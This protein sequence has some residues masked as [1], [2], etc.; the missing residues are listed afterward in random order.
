MSE[1]FHL[2]LVSD[3]TGETITSVARACLV[4]FEGVDAVEHVWNLVRTKRQLQRAIAGVENNPGVVLFTLVDAKMRTALE[5]ACRQLQVPCISLLDPA[6]AALS[7]YFGIKSRAKP[8][9]QHALDAEYFARIDA[10]NFV[11]AHDDGQLTK[12]LNE[13]DVVLV[14]ISRTSKT[15]TCIYLANRGVKAA[16][17]PLV[18]GVGLPA[19]LMRATKP[20]IVGLTKDPIPLVQIR[21]NR[22]RSLNQE[23]ETDYIDLEKVKLEVATARRVFAENDWPAIDVTRRSIEE[24]AAAILQL[25]DRRAGRIT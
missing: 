22:L 17:V 13:A 14:G 24:V 18:P 16:N 10:I 23:E 8:G 11:L 5:G 1:R 7:E 6:I 15:P 2:H 20:L 21:R 12:D 4:Q 19:E 3:S 9:L 25:H